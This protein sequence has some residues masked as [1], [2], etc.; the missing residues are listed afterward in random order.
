MDLPDLGHQN[1][2]INVHPLPRLGNYF[3]IDIIKVS[4][5]RCVWTCEAPVSHYYTYMSWA[6]AEAYNFETEWYYSEDNESD[7][8][9]PF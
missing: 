7:D 9:L 6:Y 4:T 5:G 3:R 8:P 1:Y 2:R